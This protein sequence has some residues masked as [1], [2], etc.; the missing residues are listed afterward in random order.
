MK[1]SFRRRTHLLLL[2][3]GLFLFG[4]VNAYS[5]TSTQRPGN[6]SSASPSTDPGTPASVRPPSIRQ[7][8][9]LMRQMETEAAQ[10]RTPE[11]EQL[12][13]S[14]IADDYTNIQVI[15]NK[16]MGTVIPSTAPD[17]KYIGST[18]SEIRK[19][20]DRL[21]L[22]LRLSKPDGEKVER[23]KYKPATDLLSLKAA[24]LA[25]DRAIMSF[26]QNPVFKN[27][28]VLDVKQVSQLVV[29]L[30]TILGFTKELNRDV[31]KLAKSASSKP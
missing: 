21:H 1:N 5:Q 2:L 18:I 17:F 6:N 12:A 7:R 25:L 31:E 16:M 15:N 11:E 27:P 29:D 28:D 10:P 30:E 19:R 14:Q 3:S 24:L 8:S 13:M 23:P 22:N 26:V 4:A 20:A 9:I